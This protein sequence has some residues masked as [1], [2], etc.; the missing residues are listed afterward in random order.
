MSNDAISAPHGWATSFTSK[1]RGSRWI[2]VP[3]TSGSSRE[4]PWCPKMAPKIVKLRSLDP[5]ISKDI[6]SPIDEAMINFLKFSKCW[7]KLSWSFAEAWHVSFLF[8]T[9][10]STFVAGGN[11]YASAGSAASCSAGTSGCSSVWDD[12]MLLIDK[13]T[14]TTKV[15]AGENSPYLTI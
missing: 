14:G 9:L 11:A 1:E 15:G 6:H 12:S 4:R 5:K 13:L 8:G 7:R 2:E 10:L 3:S